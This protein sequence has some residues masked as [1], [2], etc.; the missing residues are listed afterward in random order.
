MYDQLLGARGSA[1]HADALQLPVLR[2]RLLRSLLYLVHLEAVRLLGPLSVGLR[3]G[4][5]E[6]TLYDSQTSAEAMIEP[7]TNCQA[8]TCLLESITSQTAGPACMIAV[9][10]DACSSARI[11]QPLLHRPLVPSTAVL[12]INSAL[13]VLTLSCKVRRRGWRIG[14]PRTASAVY[15]QASGASWQR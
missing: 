15:C 13:P 12:R 3:A 9:V 2:L 4:L 7:V 1:P 5:R 11:S 8:C 14:S 6:V 10:A